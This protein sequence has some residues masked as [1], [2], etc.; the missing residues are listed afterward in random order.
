MPR[1]ISSQ[2]T[3]TEWDEQLQEAAVSDRDAIMKRLIF[4][5]VKKRIVPAAVIAA[6]QREKG[7][8]LREA[9]AAVGVQPQSSST[10]GGWVD[11]GV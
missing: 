11:V 5:E 10:L 8:D 1:L 2:Q 7:T 3:M 9:F 6:R 4:V